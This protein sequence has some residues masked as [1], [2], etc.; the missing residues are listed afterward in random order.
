MFW[1]C[2]LNMSKMLEVVH[3]CGVVPSDMIDAGIEIYTTNRLQ[4]ISIHVTAF[5]LTT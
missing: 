1:S 2:R 4:K 5:P 3:S